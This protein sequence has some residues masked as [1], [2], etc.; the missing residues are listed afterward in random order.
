MLLRLLIRTACCSGLA[1]ALALGALTASS[2]EFAGASSPSALPAA[3]HSTY[4]RTPAI[5]LSASTYT[6]RLRMWVNRARSDRGIRHVRTIHCLQR[7]ARR[8][9]QHLLDLGRLVHQDMGNL[10][11]ACSL[12]AAGEVLGMG[13]VTPREMVQ[14]W[15]KSRP[16]R[17]IVLGRHYR[18]DGVAARRSAATGWIACVDF[19]RR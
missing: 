18:L 14:L 15:L 13:P 4:A 16:H 1:A 2:G 7:K 17:R 19:G 5:A 8:W 6:S 12:S 11:S 3:V 10:I 9:V